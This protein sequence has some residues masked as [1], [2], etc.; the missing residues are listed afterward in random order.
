M[1][2]QVIYSSP[3]TSAVVE[4]GLA[5]CLRLSILFPLSGVSAVRGGEPRSGFSSHSVP[6]WD[7]LQ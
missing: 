1:P 4:A 7:G 3:E 6:L 5:R 2:E